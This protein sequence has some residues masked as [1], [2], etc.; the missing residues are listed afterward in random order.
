MAGR[1]WVVGGWLAGGALEDWLRFTGML[2][3]FTTGP[4][5]AAGGVGKGAGPAEVADRPGGIP[6]GSPG[7]M[8]GR[9]TAGPGGLTPGGAG[10]D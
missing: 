6:G 5:W 7:D 2:G 9:P 4:V 10:A 8:P 3:G 1:A